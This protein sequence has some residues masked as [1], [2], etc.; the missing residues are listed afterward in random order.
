MR[1][2]RTHV[3]GFI[4]V[5]AVPVPRAQFPRIRRADRRG[6]GSLLVLLRVRGS[7]SLRA[8]LSRQGADG[9]PA[10]VLRG[11]G[12]HGEEARTRPRVGRDHRRRRADRGDE[13]RHRPHRQRRRV[14]DGLHLPADDRQRDGGRSAARSRSDEGG[15][16][17]TSTR[18]AAAPDCRSASCR[19]RCRWS[20]SRRRPAAW[21]RRTS[22]A[23]CTRSRTARCASWRG[24]TS[25]GSAVR[26]ARAPQRWRK[27]LRVPARSA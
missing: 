25:R 4:G 17:A 22:P 6:H 16:R 12:V 14:S 7:R 8:T 23:I 11:D 19:S 26:T 5:Q 1:A 13:A 18:P 27:P 15:L 9:R 10:R 20:C 2:V 3:G 24:R 21:S